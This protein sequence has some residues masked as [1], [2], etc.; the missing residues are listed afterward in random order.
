VH[1]KGPFLGNKVG[2]T[3]LI[4]AEEKEN[5]DTFGRFLATEEAEMLKKIY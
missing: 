1:F 2:G 5:I 4:S 3:T